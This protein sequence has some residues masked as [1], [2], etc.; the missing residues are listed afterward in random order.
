MLVRTI[1]LL[2]VLACSMQVSAQES[3]S[4]TAIR[5]LEHEWVEAQSHN[6][7]AALDLIFDNALV[8]IE[9][10]RLVSKGDYLLR[11]KSA[12]PQPPQQIVLEPMTVRTFGNTVIVIGSYRETSV[13]D[14][15]P[16]LT[17]W[18]FVDTWVYEQERWMLVAAGA[19][20]LLK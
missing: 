3:D 4:A 1:G 17:R 14:G 9:Y 16:R 11:V 15:K 20:P 7:N 18:R 6:D 8:Y 13:K 2:L 12:K 19:T 5:A 10:G